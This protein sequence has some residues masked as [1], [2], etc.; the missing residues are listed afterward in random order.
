ML[1]IAYAMFT[2]ITIYTFNSDQV[3]QKLSQRFGS[4]LKVTNLTTTSNEKI[5]QDKTGFG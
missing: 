2:N 3:N 1:C 4:T 5:M